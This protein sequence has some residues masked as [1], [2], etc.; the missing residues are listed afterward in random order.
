ML[1][2]HFFMVVSFT[3]ICSKQLPNFSLN[4]TLNVDTLMEKSQ[5]LC[6]EKLAHGRLETLN[7]M[8]S[9]LKFYHQCIKTMWMK[10]TQRSTVLSDADVTRQTSFS[11]CMDGHYSRYLNTTVF[12]IVTY[13]HFQINLTFTFFNLKKL[14]AAC[15]YHS[16]VVCILCNDLIVG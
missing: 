15:K 10:C 11:P 3:L 8:A 4:V 7:T 1:F 6:H 14:A 9:Y 16:V 5:Q 2:L 13:P 12:R